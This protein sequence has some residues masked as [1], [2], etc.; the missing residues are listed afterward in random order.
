L[1]YSG[2]FDF[3]STCK[4]IAMPT[5]P[6]PELEAFAVALLEAA[7]APEAEAE[8]VAESL[9]DANLRGYES[10]GVM[11]IPYYAD[12]IAKREILPG[13]ELTIDD[14]S[15]SKVVADGNWGFGQVQAQRLT[16]L[17]ID[18][19]KAGGVAVGTLKQSSHVGRLGEYGEM[20]TAEGL[21]AL[22]MVNTHGVA[23]RVA[24]PGG[25]APRLGTNP[26]AIA[27]PYGDEP[28]VLDFSTSATAEGKVRVR[29]IAGEPCPPGWLLDHEGQP[30][31]DP[32]SLYGNPPGT[33]LPMGGSQAYKGFGLALM[34]DIL[35]GA[36]SGGRCARETPLNPNG[37]CMFM[38]VVDPEHF[39]G[40]H[41]FAE[42][43]TQ[44]AEFVRGC[45]R[46]AGCDEILLP[47]DPE[48]RL[49]AKNSVEGISLDAENWGALTR[50]AE[51]LGVN[52]PL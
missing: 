31:C 1:A 45:P 3:R 13:V 46:V 23:R 24:P 50:L 33:I 37:N 29:K 40:T 28:L 5:I 51:K 22:L 26:L 32:S 44:L 49:M 10:H 11:R 12:Q 27:V 18:K 2:R 14:E 47:G 21:V 16:H 20:C 19:A 8:R 41:H 34:V 43:V 6:A 52:A 4:T 7:G 15:P 30:T 36:I 48:R 39:G 9:I 35:A 38:M 42:E 17:L 25:K